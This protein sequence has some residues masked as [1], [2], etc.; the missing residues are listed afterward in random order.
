MTKKLTFFLTVFVLGL[1]FSAN[2]KA[3]FTDAD[4]NV[5]YG[6]DVI[7]TED[8]QSAFEFDGDG[9]LVYVWAAEGDVATQRVNMYAMRKLAL[10]AEEEYTL[11]ATFVPESG[12]DTSVERTYG[13]V[14]WYLDADNYL[15]YWMQQKIDGGWSAQFYGRIDGTFR[16]Y[17]TNLQ[18]EGKTPSNQVE[19]YWHSGEYNDMWWDNPHTAHPAVL[20]QRD[21][22][23]DTTFTLKVVSKIV[24]IT[25]DGKEWTGRAFELYQIIDGEEFSPSIYYVQ[26]VVEQ[27]DGFRTG[28]YAEAFNF[29]VEGF[30]LTAETDFAAAVEAEIDG[31]GEVES[32]AD[33]NRV[34]EA[35]SNYEALLDLKADVSEDKVGALEEAEASAGAYVDSLILALDQTKSTFVEDVQAVYDLYGSLSDEILAHVTKTQEL[36]EAVNAARDWEDPNEEDPNEEEPDDEDDEEDKDKKKKGCFGQIGFVMPAALL[37]GTALLFLGR[38]RKRSLGQ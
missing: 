7:A 35:R 16:R 30:S 27:G 14:V 4:G 18:L 19:D 15:L 9:N 26:G 3:A 32:A 31:L 22:L 20:R 24:T 11:Q 33:L 29:G 6:W 1:L 34:M 5:Y 13:L 28:V 12:T 21:V 17:V 36:A 8:N 23:I 38:F 37:F 2:S 25:V 10:T